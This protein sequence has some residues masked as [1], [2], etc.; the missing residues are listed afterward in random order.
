MHRTTQCFNAFCDRL[1]ETRHAQERLQGEI[2]VIARQCAALVQEN[3]AR[4]EAEAMTLQL[5]QAS[6]KPLD[7]GKEPIESAPLFGGN[8]QQE[9]F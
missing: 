6:S 2:G 3:L 7:A 9:L 4:A 8:Q 5:R 1:A